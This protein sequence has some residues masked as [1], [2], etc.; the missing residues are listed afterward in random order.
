MWKTTGISDV[1]RC[2]HCGSPS[3]VVTSDNGTGEVCH[4]YVAVRC[5]ICGAMGKQCVFE[6]PFNV[7]DPGVVLAVRAW[8]MRSDHSN[9]Y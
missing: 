2:P 4:K 6:E 7:S 9:Q 1:Y 5:R 8:N 3:E